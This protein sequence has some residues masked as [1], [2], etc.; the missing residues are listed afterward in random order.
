MGNKTVTEPWA[1]TQIQKIR[2]VKRKSSFDK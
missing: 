1:I 2:F